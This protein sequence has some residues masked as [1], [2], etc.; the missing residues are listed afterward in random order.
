[1]FSVCFAWGGE[2]GL[3][4][5]FWF[6]IK[7]LRGAG[8]A[9]HPSRLATKANRSR[10]ISAACEAAKTGRTC[11]RRPIPPPLCPLVEGHAGDAPAPMSGPTSRPS[12]AHARG[13]RRARRPGAAGAVR[14]NDPPLRAAR[15]SVGPPPR[16]CPDEQC[17]GPDTH[18]K[19]PPPPI[20]SRAPSLCP[21]NVS[22]SPSAILNGI[23]NRQ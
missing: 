13:S 9:P 4:Q 6:S 18:R 15:Q 2:G 5:L 17:S 3:V 8:Q 20:P 21:A 19:L 16:D 1:M 7:T 11:A 14:A 22:L 10:C 23:C 12:P